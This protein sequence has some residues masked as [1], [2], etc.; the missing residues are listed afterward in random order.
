MNTAVPALTSAISFLFAAM[1]LDQYLARRRP[2]QLVWALGLL[3]WGLGASAEAAVQLGGLHG[4]PYRLWYL[5]GAIYTA[6]WLGMGTVYLLAPRRVAHI[7]F[8]LLALAS[9]AALAQVISAP[10]NLS[11]LEGEEILKGVAMPLRVRLMTPFFNVFGTVALAGGA[12]WSAFVYGRWRAMPRRAISNILIALGAFL[13]A[14]GGSLARAGNPGFLY[15]SE[16]LGVIVIFS[17]F[18]LSRE[19]FAFYR[20]VPFTVRSSAGR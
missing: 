18:L 9:L 4:P 3:F 5:M 15:L 20:L 6:A 11:L 16:L 12:L 1:V 17:G 8:A 10:L 7:V 2:Y 19:V 13:P 14:I